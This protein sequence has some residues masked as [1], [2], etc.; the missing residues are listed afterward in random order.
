MTTALRR[1]LSAAILGLCVAGA[2]AN[3]AQATAASDHACCH[4]SP[5]G[6]SASADAPCHG[7]L[8]LTCCRAAALPGGD[9]GSAS[10]LSVLAT[11]DPV[12]L[13]A[14]PHVTTA[15]PAPAALAPRIAAIR[16]SVVLLL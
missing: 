10:A 7:F 9:H 3:V 11:V 8:P 16:L 5:A 15:R 12:A 13:L 4:R 6:S 2:V 14:P 1:L